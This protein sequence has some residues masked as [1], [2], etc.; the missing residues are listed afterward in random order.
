MASLQRLP[1]QP[2]APSTA[3]TK[4]IIQY[5]V[6]DLLWRPAG[7][8]VRFVAVIHPARGAC[9]LLMC[10]DTSLDAIDIIRLTTACASRSST[11][12]QAGSAPD[13]FLHL[14]FLDVQ[15]ESRGA[16]TAA[17]SISIVPRS[18]IATT[19]SASFTLTTSFIQARHHLP[20]TA[21]A[22]LLPLPIPG[23]SGTLSAPGCEPF[24]SAS[25]PP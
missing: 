19:S 12:L 2:Q 20:G 1:N 23:S 6:R 5:R 4:V 9:C 17:I 18:S 16:V 22:H 10:T 25:R 24:A 15:D 13:R 3:R 21:S 7:R 11:P 8:L 14:P